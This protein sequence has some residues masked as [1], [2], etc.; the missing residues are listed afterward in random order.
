M[1]NNWLK[2][3]K[4]WVIHRTIDRY[5]RIYISSLEPGYY[6]KEIQ[7]LHGCFDLLVDFIEG[8]LAWMKL[9][10]SDEE[11]NKV[12][13][14]MS[15][16]QYRD[17]HAREFGIAHLKLDMDLRMEMDDEGRL[18]KGDWQIN[19]EGTQGFAAK[20]MLELYLWWKDEREKE[21]EY[22]YKMS[23]GPSSLEDFSKKQSIQLLRLIKVREYMWT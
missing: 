7:M 14:Y 16:K 17:K 3:L 10:C 20:E 5:D 1:V 9:I 21:E 2:D 11:R 8:E 15:L 6:D 12:P 18:A 19:H 13:W 22:A 4:W 23:S